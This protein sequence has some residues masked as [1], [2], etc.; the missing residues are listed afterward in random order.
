MVKIV[1]IL[2]FLFAEIALGAPGS[3]SGDMSAIDPDSTQEWSANEFIGGL[4]II[5]MV[6]AF[7]KWANSLRLFNFLEADWMRPV[8]LVLII[9]AAIFMGLQVLGLILLFLS[10][11]YEWWWVFLLIALYLIF[12][13][14]GFSKFV[15]K[16]FSRG[17]IKDHSV[18]HFIP[19]N[20]TVST[21]EVE[22]L[23]RQH[24]QKVIT[25]KEAAEFMRQWHERSDE[26]EER[27]GNPSI[28]DRKYLA[29]LEALLTAADRESDGNH[30]KGPRRDRRDESENSLIAHK[31]DPLFLGAVMVPQGSPLSPVLHRDLLATRLQTLLDRSPNPEELRRRV[32]CEYMAPA[33]LMADQSQDLEMAAW[34]WVELLADAGVL[35][36][37]GAVSGRTLQPTENAEARSRLEREINDPEEALLAW[38]SLALAPL[39]S[40]G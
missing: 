9:C 34:V 12:K 29:D 17:R 4:V 14:H 3:Y 27:S 24:V 30:K 21:D 38:I 40:E 6:V 13:S 35:A 18:T 28:A 19:G 32:E 39:R 2:I 15:D 5:L 23:E 11:V 8:W 31:S 36:V 7:V 20:V 25:R 10:W 37:Q 16:T 33:G 26:R 22:T 1:A